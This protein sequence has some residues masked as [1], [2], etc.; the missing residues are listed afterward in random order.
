MNCICSINSEN[1]TVEMLKI[2]AELVSVS[3][4]EEMS[5]EVEDQD[6]VQRDVRPTESPKVHGQYTI[7][8]TVPATTHMRDPTRVRLVYSRFQGLRENRSFRFVS[9]VRRKEI[10]NRN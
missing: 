6:L 8:S 1:P 4:E 2:S 3:G 5:F 7:Y 9:F 10:N